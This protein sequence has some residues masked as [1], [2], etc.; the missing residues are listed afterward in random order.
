MTTLTEA[1]RW[2]E[3]TRTHLARSR[4]LVTHYWDDLPWDGRL[5]TDPAFAHVDPDTDADEALAATGELNDLAVL[6]LFSV[7]ESIVRERVL[8]EVGKEA[9]GIRHPI[10]RRAADEAQRWVDD[11][12]FARVLDAY[13]PAVGTDLVELVSQVRRYRN[14]VSHGRRGKPKVQINPQMAYERLQQFL[15]AIRESACDVPPPT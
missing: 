8:T 7:F 14:W 3:T 9:D 4:R 10:L 1:W 12:S 11:G 15:D 2:F 5:G 13:K 6:V